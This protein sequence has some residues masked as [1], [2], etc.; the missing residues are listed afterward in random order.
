[1]CQLTEASLMGLRSL[2]QHWRRVLAWAAFVLA[3]AGMGAVLYIVLP[4]APRWSV[5]GAIRKLL[6][7][8]EPVLATCTVRGE[9]ECGPVQV[10]DVETGL[11]LEQFLGDAPAFLALAQS[12]DR[13]Y[14]VVVLAGKDATTRNIA[15][16]D[17]QDRKSWQVQ[18]QLG[19]FDAAVFAP[20]CNYLAVRLRKVGVAETAFSIVDAR[21]GRVLRFAV[22]CQPPA[23]KD[24]SWQRWR[25]SADDGLF[26]DDGRF[27]AVNRAD[28]DAMGMILV[29]TESGKINDIPDARVRALAPK[30]RVLIAER[31]GTDW[32]F[33]LAVMDWRAPLAAAAP[34]TLHFSSDRR[35]L[36][37]GARPRRSSQC[38]C[39]FLTCARASCTGKSC[40]SPAVPRNSRRS[41]S[42]RTGVS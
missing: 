29:D 40:R 1:M 19:E 14:F 28:D 15:W 41:A 30:S 10:W 11:E 16:V 38:P 27:F 21:T 37:S 20:M 25:N 34:E 7:D 42:R 6:T 17:L 12:D 32:I 13:R 33:D 2:L 9:N 18:A 23:L 24:D 26:T 36:A 8:E 4:P 39:G 5:A 3:L 22:P 31:D 35:W